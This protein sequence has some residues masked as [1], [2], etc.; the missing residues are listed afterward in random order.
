MQNTSWDLEQ[1]IKLSNFESS[2]KQVTNHLYAFSP[3]FKEL[4]QKKNPKTY[5][6]FITKYEEVIEELN[7]L[8]A[9]AMLWEEIDQS[10][11]K[12]KQLK[13]RVRNLIVEFETSTR[14]VWLWL[15][16]KTINEG[17]ILDERSAKKLF[18]SIP[19]LEYFVHRE[20]ELG[21]H[22]L[23]DREEGIVLRKDMVG[24][25]PLL[26]LRSQIETRQRYWI[27]IRGK[28]K[29]YKTI[30]ELT[31]LFQSPDRILRQATYK[32]F[33]AKYKENLSSYAII[34]E[35]IVKD[36]AYEANDRK[37]TSPINVRNVENDIPDEIISSLIKVTQDSRYIFEPFF[38]WKAKRLGLKKLTRFDLH[39]PYTK[40]NKSKI[41]YSITKKLVLDV[42]EQTDLDFYDKAKSLFDQRHIDAFPNSLKSAGGFCMTFSKKISPYIL[43]NYT[44]VKR[45]ALVMAHELGHGIHSMF[46]NE[47]SILT[48]EAP[49]VL[50]ETASTFGEMLVFDHFLALAKDDNEKAELLSD[51]ISD[52]YATIVKQIYLVIFEREA[53][54]KIPQGLNLEDLNEMYLKTVKEQYGNSVEI[55]DIFKYEWAYIAHIFRSPFYCYAYAFG[56]LLALA[57]YHEYKL[58]GKSYLDKIK[59]ILSSGGSQNP[60]V[61]LKS[62]GIDISKKTFW[63]GGFDQINLWVQELLRLNPTV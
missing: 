60:E 34:Y 3:L 47:Q 53:H 38:K 42:F 33:M 20:R 43:L 35:A 63:E 44:G 32:A 28:K 14:P 23:T 6:N 25:Q 5:I 7:I 61:L 36:W 18:G 54:E 51:K 21:K 19:R 27:N 45:D 24:S 2:F 10:N 57:L 30:A 39:A 8:Y 11:S 40:T 50:A 59:I 56:D 26:D 62:V 49:L 52:T 22:N 48:I 1:I 17:S 46:S 55:P 41:P 31:K 13:S 4:S 58:R 16:G 15:K 9:R 37:Y 12:A 29:L